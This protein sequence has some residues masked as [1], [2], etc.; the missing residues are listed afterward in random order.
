MNIAT[1]SEMG[2][3][4]MDVI[5]KLDDYKNN[6]L[7]KH[8]NHEI[9]K[10]NNNNTLNTKIKNIFNIPTLKYNKYN[11]I[12]NKPISINTLYIQ[13]LYFNEEPL[14]IK[15]INLFE[16]GL[17]DKFP[18]DYSSKEQNIVLDNMFNI[19]YN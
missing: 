19:S 16:E 6:T 7:N 3:Y 12:P 4:C 5:D 10:I 8:N 13:E 11:N 9:I 2:L 18:S 14:N 17:W 15:N 1:E